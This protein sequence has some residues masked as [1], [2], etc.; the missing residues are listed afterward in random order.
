MTRQRAVV[1]GLLALVLALVATVVWQASV[2]RDDRRDDDRLDAAIAL[3]KAQVLDITTLDSDS[4]GDKLRAMSARTSGDFKDQVTAIASSFV[5]IVQEKKIEATGRIDGIGVSSA[6]DKDVSVLVASTA[7]VSESGKA[8]P[9]TRTYRI[10]VKL[11]R[12]GAT[13]KINGMEFV[14]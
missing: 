12:T 2:L 6:T 14:Q 13:W 10:R 7:V 9:T 3:A 4:V 8:T 5:K 11:V 1:A